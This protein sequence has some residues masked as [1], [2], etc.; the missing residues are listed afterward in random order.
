MADQ[1]PFWQPFAVAK[2]NRSSRDRTD[3]SSDGEALFNTA[4]S[5][6]ADLRAA[7]PDETLADE[8]QPQVDEGSAR[9]P[10]APYVLKGKLA[11]QKEKKGRAGKTATRILGLQLDDAGLT[12]LARD[13]K[14]QLGCGAVVEDGCVVLLGDLAE[15]AAAWLRENGAKRVVGD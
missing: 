13:M 11:V 4:F 10:G 14:R 8:P 3:A 12:A 15:R 7:L 6:L 1:P 5:A 9:L 2:R